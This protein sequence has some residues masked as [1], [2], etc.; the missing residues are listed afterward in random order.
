VKEFAREQGLVYAEF[1]FI[2]GNGEVLSVL[3]N[4]AEQARIVGMVAGHEICQAM[5]KKGQ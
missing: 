1:G 4:V 5:E 2:S 3:K